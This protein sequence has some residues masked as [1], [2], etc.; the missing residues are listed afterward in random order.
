AETAFW[1]PHLLLGSDG[2]ASFEFTVPDSVT[3]W[4]VWVHAITTDLRAG[5]AHKETRSLKELMV[6]PY[7]PRFFR[8]GDEAE[9]KV[10]V[11]NASETE[12]TGTLDFDV[13]DPETNRSLRDE[14]KL[15]RTSLPFKVA[16]GGGT[17]LSFPLIAP[18]RVGTVAFRVNARAGALSDGELRPLPVLPSRY[19]LAQSRFVVLKDKS[20]RVMH[21][22]DL[23][24]NDDPTLVNGQMVVTVDAQLF[25][26]VLKALPY[27]VE[28]PYECTEQTMNRFLSTGIVSSV[29][30][31]FPA[32]A[33]MAKEMARRDTPL[34]TWDAADLN[35]R[36]TLEESP[37][38][39]EAKGG[40]A[41]GQALIKLLDPKVAAAHRDASLAKLRQMQTSVG[42]FP[43]FPGGP[44]SPYITLYLLHGFAK[45]A[46]FGVEVP[47]DMVQRAWTYVGDHMRGEWRRMM[48]ENCCWEFLTFLNYT[49]SAYPDE[50]FYAHALSHDARRPLLD[51]SFR[52]WKHHS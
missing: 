45:A 39:R 14:F 23:A 46:E 9:V 8:E 35:R 21:F 28:Y 24:K 16:P 34:E 32:V 36:M 42:G 10:V 18:R 2:S 33:S 48:A 52:H 6:R 29:F 26:T 15:G 37:W 41:E 27:L 43:W 11:N 19:H 4:N 17:N 7:V 40:A 38:L 22:A 51:F 20:S 5:A 50:S 44:P 47:R 1:Q 30:R 3:S 49:A 12:L 25:Y 31:D 13:V